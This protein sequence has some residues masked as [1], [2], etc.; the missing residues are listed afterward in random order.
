MNAP[1]SDV[2]FVPKQAIAPTPALYVELVADGM[3]NLAKASL[4]CVPAIADGAI[5]NDNGCGPGAASA[6]VAEAI[7]GRSLNVS[8]KATDINEDALKI[9]RQRSTEN[10]WPAEAINMDATA[11]T[12]SDET[13]TLSLNNAL[14]FF[15]PDDSGIDVVKE[16]YRTLK[17]GGKAVFNSWKY[18]P[19]LE[20]IQAAAK[21]TRPE[22]TPLPRVDA[23]KW[24]RAEFLQSV[25]E[26]GGFEK[27][28]VIIETRDVSVTTSEMDRYANMLWSFIGGTSP[29]GWLHSD[30][31]NWDNA[32]NV[33]KQEL[34]K[35]EGYQQLPGGKNL[36]KF[37]ANVAV[38]TK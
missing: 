37:V 26:Q 20:P 30:E 7:S 35:T 18:I 2:K 32:I 15:L 23:E 9:Y 38:A 33:V 4:G 5:I 19:N 13:F 29:V 10:H 25:I 1:E 28:K 34:R 8:I 24:S 3:E 14:L 16:V 12:F 17:P 31:E 11:L 36:L 27:D 22:G 21:A 6:A